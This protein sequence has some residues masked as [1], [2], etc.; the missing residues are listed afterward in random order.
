MSTRELMSWRYQQ[1]SQQ[2]ASR[3]GWKVPYLVHF[4]VWPPCGEMNYSVPRCSRKKHRVC[5]FRHRQ[6]VRPSPHMLA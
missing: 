6:H 2:R 5:A 1:L 3:R 4:V